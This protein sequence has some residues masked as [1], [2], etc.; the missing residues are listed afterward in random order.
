MSYFSILADFL[1]DLDPFEPLVLWVDQA[2]PIFGPEID[3]W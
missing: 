1:A 2:L 3:S